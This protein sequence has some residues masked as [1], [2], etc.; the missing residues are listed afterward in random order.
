M[1]CLLLLLLSAVASAALM[2]APPLAPMKTAPKDA[3]LDKALA[4]RGGGMVDKGT[5]VKGVAALFGLYAL[6]MLAIP[7]KLHDDH[8]T[9]PHT[10]MTNFWLRGT[11]VTFIAM[12]YTLVKHGECEGERRT[13][14][15]LAGHSDG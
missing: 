8:F 15:A 2:K 13:S 10:T 5:Y 3:A 7:G 14:A 6:Q 12:M 1:R 4:I 9:D 11:G